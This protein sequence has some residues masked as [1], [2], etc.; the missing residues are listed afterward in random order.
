MRW[1]RGN[2]LMMRGH[3]LLQVGGLLMLWM[4][5]LV[6]IVALAATFRP[7]WLSGA[8]TVLV[9]VGGMSIGKWLLRGLDSSSTA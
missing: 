9:L 5:L 3:G 8:T 4:L 1:E 2:T 7:V 6:S